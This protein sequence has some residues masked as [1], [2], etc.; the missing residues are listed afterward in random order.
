MYHISYFW[1][2]HW[3]WSIS[4][5]V[6]WCLLVSNG[7]IQEEHV[8]PS[9]SSLFM[10][11]SILGSTIW[12]SCLQLTAKAYEKLGW[13]FFVS[14]PQKN[15]LFRDMFRFCCS[16]LPVYLVV[17]NCSGHLEPTSE[18]FGS[19]NMIFDSLGSYIITDLCSFSGYARWHGG[20]QIFSWLVMAMPFFCNPKVNSECCIY[21]YK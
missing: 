1:K 15:F 7:H 18:S 9:N 2:E 17:L 3:S 10:H 8:L 13:V 20:F 12:Y 16:I 14:Q 11:S 6:K 19:H 5:I 21:L 4:C